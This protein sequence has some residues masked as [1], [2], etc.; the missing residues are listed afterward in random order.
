MAENN[1]C[2]KCGAGRNQ[3][4]TFTLPKDWLFRDDCDECDKRDKE[5]MFKLGQAIAAKE[6]DEILKV[7]TK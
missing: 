4:G 1:H 6:D 7:L 5:R 3:D 2:P